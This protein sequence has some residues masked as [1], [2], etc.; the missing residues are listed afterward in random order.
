MAKN[1]MADVARM[2]GV[3]LGQE[4]KI[5]DDHY[6]Y[7]L[8]EDGLVQESDGN[9]WLTTAILLKLLRG[10]VEIVKVPWQPKDGEHYY[11][12]AADFQYSCPAA[13]HNSPI[14]FALKEAGMIFKTK[15]E[16]DVTLPELRKKYLGGDAE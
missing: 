7:K 2:L 1:Y 6:I 12:P 16:C 13:W 5:K 9:R 14:D 15:A 8:I 4:F 10:N 3:E 11:F